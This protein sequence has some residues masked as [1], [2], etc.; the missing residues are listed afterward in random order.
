MKTSTRKV[1]QDRKCYMAGLTSIPVRQLL[2]TD[3]AG[4]IQQYNI[5]QDRSDEAC[6]WVLTSPAFTK[7]IEA[8]GS[9]ALALSG[10]MGCGKTFTVAFIVDHLRSLDQHGNGAAPVI[11]SYYC[12][13]DG[14]SDNAKTIL[15]SLLSQVL[16]SQEPLKHLFNSWYQERKTELPIDPTHATNELIGFLTKLLGSLRRCVFVTLDGL[17]ECDSE[18]R[19][20][21]LDFLQGLEKDDGHVKTLVS[22]RSGTIDSDNLSARSV[23]IQVPTLHARDELIIRHLVETH[24]A[25]LRESVRSAVVAEM[26]P[27][28]EGSAIWSKMIVE[29]LRKTKMTKARGILKE[30]RGLPRARGLEQVYHRIFAQVAEDDAGS[31]YILS[32]AL[33]I[34]AGAFRALTLPELS[35]AVTIEDQHGECA[36]T[37]EQLT[38]EEDRKRLLRLLR[39]FI[40][41]AGSKTND[42]KHVRLVHQSLKQLVLTSP[43]NT[44]NQSPKNGSPSLTREYELNGL[45]LRLCVRYLLIEDF[46]KLALVPQ[47]TFVEAFGIGIF[48]DSPSNSDSSSEKSSMIPSWV[49]PEERGFGAFFTYAA[50]FWTQHLAQAPLQFVPDLQDL[51]DLSIPQSTLLENWLRLEKM[52][53]PDWNT[54][55]DTEFVLEGYNPISLIVFFGP[56]PVLTA[57]LDLGLEQAGLKEGERQYRAIWSVLTWALCHDKFAV[58]RE[59]FEH[60]STT[61]I[62]GSNADF[63]TLLA[64]NERLER[65]EES[66]LWERLVRDAFARLGKDLVQHCNA[67]LHAASRVGCLSLVKKLFLAAET[68]PAVKEQLRLPAEGTLGAI[69]EAALMGHAETVRYLCQQPGMALHLRSRDKNGDNIF[70][71]VA[72]NANAEIYRILVLFY[73]EGVNDIGSGTTPLQVVVNHCPNAEAVRVLLREGNADVNLGEPFFAPL[74]CAV[75]N[76][77]PDICR[78]LVEE[79]SAD[80]QSVI[81]LSDT[82]LPYLTEQVYGP[83][84]PLLLNKQHGLLQELCSLAGLP[85]IHSTAEDG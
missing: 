46:A 7:W 80:P 28:A 12:K 44:W 30:L 73:P 20:K 77:R 5:I 49:D 76:A 84:D 10:D 18:S 40:S 41:T 33:E 19:K 43:P 71:N 13:S 16:A 74:R 65:S 50:C 79:G 36:R 34:L 1:S 81:A 72:R 69:G 3:R 42:L 67:I 52:S 27:N 47:T 55:R 8:L 68:D 58:V 61:R 29:Y 24:L 9:N 21:L 31:T 54:F 78:L 53:R 56:L 48:D 35:L 63:L 75:R 51:I 60:P 70:H 17:D 38:E 2:D 14:E 57:L 11:C 15:R 32:R 45:V 26:T 4:E 6:R 37:L 59:L 23:H 22:F 39:P 62:V 85:Y 83:G 66:E 25:D 82:G 64:Q